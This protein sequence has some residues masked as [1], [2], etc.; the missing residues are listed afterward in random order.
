MMCQWLG[1]G[2]SCSLP[3]TWSV[4]RVRDTT[5]VKVKLCDEHA[6]IVAD[7]YTQQGSI[8][9]VMGERIQL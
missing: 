1:L 3:P 4:W 5:P 6:K 9:E 2:K 7:Y 8:N